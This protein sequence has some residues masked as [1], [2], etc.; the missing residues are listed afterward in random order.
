V[1][2]GGECG[3]PNN[4]KFWRT[5]GSLGECLHAPVRFKHD[6]SVDLSWLVGLNPEFVGEMNQ[7]GLLYCVLY[8]VNLRVPTVLFFQADDFFFNE[9]PKRRCG[10]DRV[11][12]L[13]FG[14]YGC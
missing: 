8:L 11:R 12:R 7:C 4:C 9:I 6:D 5:R 3:W 2:L 14:S 13:D 10:S 1:R